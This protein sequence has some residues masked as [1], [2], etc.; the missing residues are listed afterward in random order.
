MRRLACL[1]V[2]CLVSGCSSPSF[3]GQWHTD[4]LP[5]EGM[6]DSAASLT[7]IIQPDQTFSVMFDDADGTMVVGVNGSWTQVSE[8]QIALSV[9]DGPEGT[10]EMLDPDTI[11]AAGNGGAVRMQRQ[12]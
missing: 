12:K 5:P 2:I 7:M 9:P 3:V 4:T 11:L 6:P 8:S 10:A 1:A